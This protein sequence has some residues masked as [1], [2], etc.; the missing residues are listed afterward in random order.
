MDPKAMEPYV[1]WFGFMAY[2]LHG[3]WDAAV[4][5]IGAL[6]RPQ[7]DLRDITNDTLPLWFDKLDPA[8]VNLGLA[9]YGRGYTL[10]DK[11]CNYMGCSFSGPSKPAACTNFEG[12]MSN[13]EIKRLIKDKSL[14]PTLIDG[15]QVKQITWDDQ[16]IGYDDDETFAAKVRTANSLCMGGTM[17][18]SIDFDSGSGSGD[19]PDDNF[20]ANSTGSSSG[21]GNN[22]GS[23][24]GGNSGA[25]SSGGNSGSGLVYVDPSIWTD[26]QPLAACEPPCVL[27][28]PPMQLPSPTVISFP[29]VTTTYVVSSEAGGAAGQG[30]TPTLV[31][32]TTAIAVP[33]VTT[34]EI[35]M[36]AITIFTDDP[37]AA[38]FTPVQSV[39]PHPV[40]ADFP[41]P[42]TKP[43]STLDA[44]IAS[45]KSHQTTI[46]PQATHS[47]DLPPRP[48]VSYTRGPPKQTCTAHCGH[49]DCKIFGCGGGCSLFGCGG[50]CGLLGCGGGCGIAGCG[51]G[52]GI[53]GCGGCGL[54]GCGKACPECAPNI[55]TTGGDTTGGDEGDNNEDD[56]EDEED[57]D[58][59][60]ACLLEEADLAT[61]PSPADGIIQIDDVSAIPGYNPGDDTPTPTPSQSYTTLT[62]PTVTLTVTPTPSP[63]AV[64]TGSAAA[65]WYNYQITNMMGTWVEDG[66]GRLHDEVSGCGD[67]TK[68]QWTDDEGD[69]NGA[70]VTFRTPATMKKGCV[71]RA[72]GSAG[73]PKVD[74]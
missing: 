34:T 19:V 56:N 67:V 5:T 54:I 15:A 25:N 21:G 3:S 12:V 10:S 20:G 42:P 39:E 33:P 40:I 73:G 70:S 52:C 36:W 46:Y 68:W 28:L 11:A 38:T 13:R 7:T 26:S 32:V 35:Q 6:V 8:K 64:C 18:W 65:L 43:Q 23:G 4:K 58:E 30:G 69:G 27:V 14:T 53:Q 72:I 60:K 24:S 50:N 17:I 29:P 44:V 48:A 61:G 16:W 22:P 57:E 45:M 51:G 47:V 41:G 71:G 74:C 9:Y 59:T 63:Q 66:G 37:L 1:D 49:H 31:T 62:L 55:D 2:D